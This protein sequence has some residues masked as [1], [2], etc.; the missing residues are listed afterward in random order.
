MAERQGGGRPRRGHRLS[1]R[2]RRL[3]YAWGEA[4]QLRYELFSFEA[5]EQKSRLVS[6]IVQALIAAFCGFMAFL[7]LNMVLLMRFWEHRVLLCAV[8]AGV[9]LLACLILGLWLRRRFRKM[10]PP[11]EATVGEL[12]KDLQTLGSKT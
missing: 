5:Q 10:P 6:M 3:A 1:D 12:R 9:Y 7:L 2:A 8:L 11:F 4:L